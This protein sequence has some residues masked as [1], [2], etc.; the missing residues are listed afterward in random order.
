VL[1]RGD[2]G[3]GIA[4]ASLRSPDMRDALARQDG[5]YSVAVRSGEGAA[6]RVIGSVG[7]VL[8]ALEGAAALVARMADPAVRIVTVTQVKYW[9]GSVLI[10]LLLTGRVRK[11]SSPAAIRTLTASR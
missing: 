11:I 2:L 6:L 9:L 3:W 7:E 10:V 4:A 5:L 1:G 8:V